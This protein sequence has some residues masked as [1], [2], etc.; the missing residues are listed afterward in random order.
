MDDEEELI[1]NTMRTIVR[2]LGEE[3]NKIMDTQGMENLIALYIREKDLATLG[4]VF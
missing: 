2:I 3:V 4:M 1:K